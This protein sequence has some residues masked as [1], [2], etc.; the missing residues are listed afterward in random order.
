[1]MFGENLTN[2]ALVVMIAIAVLAMILALFY[3]MLVGS[4]ANKRVKAIA[5]TQSPTSNSKNASGN[6]KQTLRQRL[7]EDPKDQRRK[8]IAES[9]KQN[10]KK[11]KKLS[12]KQKIA[13]AGL[14]A[15]TQKFWTMS[16]GFGVILALGAIAMGLS[17]LVALGAFFVG[18]FGLPR[19]F[20]G[21]LIKRRQ[22]K[23]LNDFADAIDVMVRGLK[24]GL[25]V[26]DAM[27]IIATESG[28]PVGPEFTEVVE[29]QR[30][31]IPL[32]TGI[33]RRR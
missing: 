22:N 15:T 33:E 17:F 30:V 6:V 14:T 27:K 24:A 1:M 7:T 19:W 11:K 31:G 2:I 4:S 8:Q 5:G 20:L 12:L 16:L 13:Q 32:D 26:T 25:P 23:F 9:L 3:P 21:F 29:G 10:D 28:P 18:A